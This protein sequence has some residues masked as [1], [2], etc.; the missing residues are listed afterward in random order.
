VHYTLV[1]LAVSSEQLKMVLSGLTVDELKA[2][3]EEL[4]VRVKARKRKDKIIEGI[5]QGTPQGK[6]GELIARAE[7]IARERAGG[8]QQREMVS[9][10]GVQQDL[11][12]E[13]SEIRRILD[14]RLPVRVLSFREF[15]KAVVDEYWRLGGSF[16]SYEALRDAVCARIMIAPQHF[17]VWF[18]DLV[19]A[20][21]GRITV[22]ESRTS[23]GRIVHVLMK[24]KTPEEVVWGG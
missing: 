19:W 5:L 10:T 12:R 14:E 1:V 3:A 18:S 6:M 20:S 9:P 11:L 21:A 4:G 7:K 22:G 16:V 15:A 17:D 8:E 24:A 2:L 23:K 13:L